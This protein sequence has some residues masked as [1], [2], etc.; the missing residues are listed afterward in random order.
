MIRRFGDYE[1]TKAYGDYQQLPKGGYVMQIRDV[2]IEANK[3]GSGEHLEVSADIFEG[4][5]KNFFMNDWKNQQSEDKKWK[6]R[7]WVNI[8]ADDGSEQDAWTKRRFK[9]F[10]EAVEDSNEGYHF[11]W[12]ETKFKGKLVGDLFNEREWEAQ[13][14]QIRRSTNWGGV[15]SVEKIRAGSYTLPKDRLINR[16]YTAAAPAA[17]DSFTQL[18]DDDLADLPFK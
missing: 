8:P 5:Y 6:G 9:T 7:F 14:G 11:D 17:S 3:S 13:D 16:G 12:D 15:C 4:E 10:T 2:K 18:N 1:Q